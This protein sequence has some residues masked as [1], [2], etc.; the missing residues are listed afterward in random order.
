MKLII[1]FKNGQ[2]EA[3]D[4]VFAYGWR[5]DYCV[6]IEIETE[7]IKSN[8]YG[9]AYYYIKSDDVASI[10]EITGNIVNV[11]KKQ[12]DEFVNIAGRGI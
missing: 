8:Y 2:K 9:K 11:L 5:D 3:F 10:T 4:D 6:D 12:G 1:E 7:I